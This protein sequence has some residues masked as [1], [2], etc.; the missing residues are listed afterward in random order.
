ML[1]R[2]SA[3]PPPGLKV[4]VRITGANR[5]GSL[6]FG[7]VTDDDIRRAEGA[8]V[9]A[10]EAARQAE[11]E[12][13]D[14]ER[15]FEI[16]RLTIALTGVGDTCHCG[17]RDCWR[18]G[19]PWDF[20]SSDARWFS[21]VRPTE[22][23]YRPAGEWIVGI[24]RCYVWAARRF[25]PGE[26]GV[27]FRHVAADDGALPDVPSV[28]SDLHSRAMAAARLAAEPALAALAAAK[29]QYPDWASWTGWP[30][31]SRDTPSEFAIAA[32]RAGHGRRTSEW[33]VVRTTESGG[34]GEYTAT[35]LGAQ[36]A[37]PVDGHADLVGECW[38]GRDP[39]HRTD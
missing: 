36:V 33:S 8:I 13:R 26:Y 29:L 9:S 34:Y 4:E 3:V 39:D 14:A 23:H 24:E 19:V 2:R 11:S 25:R 17:Q 22:A 1:D 38:R 32:Y 20:S 5:D 16:A 28:A 21:R 15:A 30:S 35:T 6:R 12:R 7:V 10:A 18:G 27:E 31:A 37:L